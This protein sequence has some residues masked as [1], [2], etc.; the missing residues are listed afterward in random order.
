MSISHFLELDMAFANLAPYRRLPCSYRGFNV[1]FRVDA[2]LNVKY[3]AIVI[4]NVNGDGELTAVELKEGLSGTW[5]AMHPSWGAQ[6]NKLN[7]GRHY[8]RH[9]LSS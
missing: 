6:W 8:N 2:G 3:L 1:A 5:M 7:A 4:E 9:S